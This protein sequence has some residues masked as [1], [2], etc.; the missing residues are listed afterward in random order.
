MSE[1]ST[2]G[3]SEPKTAAAANPEDTRRTCGKYVEVET[4]SKGQCDV[5]CWST[6]LQSRTNAKINKPINIFAPLNVNTKLT[7]RL[8]VREE[9]P[10]SS[11][12]Q[13]SPV[14]AVSWL[15]RLRSAFKGA[16]PRKQ[17]ACVTKLSVWNQKHSNQKPVAWHDWT[18][19]S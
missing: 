19:Y 2:E 16:P 5:S 7:S 9:A 17:S 13:R 6:R 11:C 12:V 15:S 3:A 10:L 1:I 8:L 14:T 18:T 4:L